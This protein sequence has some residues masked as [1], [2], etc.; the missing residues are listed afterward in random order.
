M[1]DFVVHRA[2]RR[3]GAPNRDSSESRM[4]ELMR[5]IDSQI[6]LK[7]LTQLRYEFH[8]C[9]FDIEINACK[10]YYLQGERDKV[11]GILEKIRRKLLNYGENML[12]RRMQNNDDMGVL[13]NLPEDVMRL[14]L[15]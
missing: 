12:L 8:D 6:F 2:E 13:G 15:A 4:M 1:E 11:L 5:A 14:I 3:A 9:D 7:K 10:L